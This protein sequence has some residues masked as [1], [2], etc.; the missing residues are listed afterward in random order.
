[1]SQPNPYLKRWAMLAS[2]SMVVANGCL[3]PSTTRF[4]HLF[5]AEDPELQRREAQVQDPY[6]D[7]SLGPSVGFRPQSFLQQR[8]EPQQV[9]DRFYNGTIRNQMSPVPTTQPVGPGAYGPFK[10]PGAVQ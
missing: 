10:Y 7:A 4:P 8:S 3:N 2:V 1:M 6:P 5:S 9:K